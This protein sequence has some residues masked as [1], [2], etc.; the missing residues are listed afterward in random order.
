MIETT[1]APKNIKELL[2]NFM[3]EFNDSVTRKT[4]TDLLRLNEIEAI[5]NEYNNPPEVVAENKLIIDLF[6]LNTRV[7]L[8]NKGIDFGELSV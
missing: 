3:F 1:T 5:C 7:I 8:S 6:N 2:D 4:V